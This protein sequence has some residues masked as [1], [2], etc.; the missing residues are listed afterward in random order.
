[1]IDFL[2]YFFMSICFWFASTASIGA[3]ILINNNN[4]PSR[5]D[6]VAAYLRALFFVYVPITLFVKAPA[7]LELLAFFM[8]PA[9]FTACVFID[10]ED[11][12]HVDLQV[13]FDF[14]SFNEPGGPWQDTLNIL[15]GLLKFRLVRV[16]LHRARLLVAWI[17]IIH[18]LL[19]SMIIGE[20]DRKT[21][22][23]SLRSKDP[24]T[25]ASKAKS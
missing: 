6:F 20:I 10:F 21:L 14:E 9:L 19:V 25:E 15:I 7:S 1:M 12:L 17:A 16:L 5:R 4:K 18:I 8:A 2:L 22:W 13:P 24:L 11:F 3:Q 23:K